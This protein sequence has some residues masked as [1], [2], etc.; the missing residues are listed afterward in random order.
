MWPNLQLP[1]IQKSADL[2]TFTEEIVNGKLHF[3]CSQKDKNNNARKAVNHLLR[4]WHASA[5]IDN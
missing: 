1:V 5:N 2:V 4:Y 3:L